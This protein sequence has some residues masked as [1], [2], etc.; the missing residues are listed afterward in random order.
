MAGYGDDA[1]LQ[2]WLD[3]RG[4]TVPGA[5]PALAVLRQ[6]GSDYVDATY[7]ARFRGTPTDG[8]TQER[9]WPRTGAKVFGAA[10]DSGV[11]PLAVINASYAAAWQEAQKAGS[12]FPSALSADKKVKSQKVDVLQVSYQD[13]GEYPGPYDPNK[14]ESSTPVLAEVYNMLKPYLVLADY[15]I[16]ITALGPS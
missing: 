12:L 1:G 5:A 10:V 13:G 4:Y 15:G 6:R 3:G 16:G 9:Q 11:V 2:D 14:P 7:G 8:I